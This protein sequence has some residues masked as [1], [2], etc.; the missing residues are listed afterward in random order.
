MEARADGRVEG[1]EEKGEEEEKEEAKEEGRGQKKKEKKK[2]SEVAEG[3]LRRGGGVSCW[4]K[5][6]RRVTEPNRA[7]LEL[8]LKQL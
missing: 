8:E 1:V 2:E 4:K 5:G 7:P 3:S 6:L